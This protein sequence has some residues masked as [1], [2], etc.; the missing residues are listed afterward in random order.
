MQKRLTVAIGVA[1]VRGTFAD[2]QYSFSKPNG[3]EPYEGCGA[4]PADDITRGVV[5]RERGARAGSGGREAGRSMLTVRHPENCAAPR[6]VR[7]ASST[8]KACDP[9]NNEIE[10]DRRRSPKGARRVLRRAANEIVALA[11][12][13]RSGGPRAHSH[14]KWLL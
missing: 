3:W 11:R 4:S 9:C 8:T 13:S 14:A 7:R 12:S 2:S 1:S 6:E 5:A 10:D